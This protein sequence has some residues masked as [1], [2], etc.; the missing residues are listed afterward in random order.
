MTRV[1]RTALGKKPSAGKP[2]LRAADRHDLDALWVLEQACF[3][4]DRFSRRSYARALANPRARLRVI[5]AG[6]QLLAAGL[7]FTRADSRAA[8]LYSIAVAPA[9]RGL[10][11]GRRLLLALE[12]QARRLGCQEMRLEVKTGNLAA[13][14]LYRESGYEVVGRLAAYYE[15][16]ADALRL[17]RQFSR[18]QANRASPCM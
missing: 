17:A 1:E 6:G 5:E 11:L 10:G 14:A 9:A 18:R 7:I 12:Q 4:T 13:L 2:R 15:D 16:G 3:R 8:R